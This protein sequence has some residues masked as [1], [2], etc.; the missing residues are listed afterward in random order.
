VDLARYK[1]TS[2]EDFLEYSF[3]SD[4]PKGIIRKMIRFTKNETPLG[5][6]YNLG[7][8]DWNEQEQRIDDLIKSSNQDVEKI[9]AT[10]AAAVVDFSN[11]Y[12]DAIIYAEGSTSARTRRYQMEINKYLAEIESV[13]KVFGNLE[14]ELF[15]PFK[16]GIK[17][18]SFIAVR[19][20]I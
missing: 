9:F 11:H 13:F 1:L 20:T 17:Y 8:G 3:Y 15:V 7:F 6:I 2:S 14:H 10:I 19:K 12:P 5:N 4:G 16:P 18:L